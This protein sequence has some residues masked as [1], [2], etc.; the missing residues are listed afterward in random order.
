MCKWNGGVSAGV[1]GYRK[2]VP[3]EPRFGDRCRTRREISEWGH[4]SPRVWRDW[5]TG[6]GAQ[7]V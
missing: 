4:P 2:L 7:A 5:L 3:A 6:L 1:S